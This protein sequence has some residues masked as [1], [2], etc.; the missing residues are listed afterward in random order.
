MNGIWHQLDL[1]SLVTV[2]MLDMFLLASVLAI[3]T[4]VSRRLGF[5]REDEIAIV[6]RG[7]KK[8][9]ERDEIWLDRPMRFCRFKML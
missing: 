8:S 1:R 4:I 5:S 7:S 3:T 2:A 6:F 9:L